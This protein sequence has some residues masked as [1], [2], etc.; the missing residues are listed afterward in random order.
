LRQLYGL[1]FPHI[2]DWARHSGDRRP[3]DELPANQ[4]PDPTRLLS[5]KQWVNAY[6]SGDYVGRNLWRSEKDKD[7]YA[8]GDVSED[9]AGTR[10][11]FCIGGGA[12]THYWDKTAPKIVEELDRLIANA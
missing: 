7:V 11:E 8:L 10:R 1:R 9:A 3:V 2:Y 5:V 4:L 12:H 6:R